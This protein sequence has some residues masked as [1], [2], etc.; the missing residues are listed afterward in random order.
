[1]VLRILGTGIKRT[2]VREDGRYVLDLLSGERIEFTGELVSVT[3]IDFGVE[4]KIKDDD[5]KEES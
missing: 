4:L 3:G 5:K 2:S 1:M